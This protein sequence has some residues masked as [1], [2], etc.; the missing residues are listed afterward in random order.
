MRSRRVLRSI[1]TPIMRGRTRGPEGRP[2]SASGVVAIVGLDLDGADGA[3]AGV[4]VGGVVEGLHGGEYAPQLVEGQGVEALAQIVVAWHPGEDGAP[5]EGLDIHA[6][7]ATHDGCFASAL[8]RGD[9]CAGFVEVAEE[10]KHLAGWSHVDH[11]VGHF[12][13]FVEVFAGAY[14]HGAVDLTGVGRDNLAAY[15]AG[16]VDGAGCLA[17]SGGP[18]DDY[19]IGKGMSEGMISRRGR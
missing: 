2:G 1:S 8:D 17:R 12:A 18:C 19:H 14:V 9:G 7:S 4:G 13:I 10:I 6:R 3:G 11:M 15:C 5:G 16:K